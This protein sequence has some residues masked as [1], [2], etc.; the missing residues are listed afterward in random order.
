VLTRYATLLPRMVSRLRRPTRSIAVTHPYLG[1]L[2]LDFGAVAAGLLSEGF[3]TVAVRAPAAWA[4]PST[5]SPCPAILRDALRYAVAVETEEVPPDLDSDRQPIVRLW[6]TRLAQMLAQTEAAFR[7]NRPELVVLVQGYEPVNAVARAAALNLGIP[8]LAIENT[9]INSRMLWDNVSAITTNRSLAAN[10]YWRY[11]Q[12]ISEEAVSGFVESFTSGLRGSKSAEHSAPVGSTAPDCGRPNVLFLGQVFT[13]SSIVFGLGPWLS[14]LDVIEA[15]VDWCQQQGYRLLL[16]LHPKESMGNATI[17]DKPYDRLTYRRIQGR[18]A[19]MQALEENQAIVDVDNRFDTY[20]LL[21]QSDIAVTINSQAGLEAALFGK[22]AVV[23]GDAFYRGLGF[24]L[25][26]AHPVHFDLTMA[27]AITQ[28][29]RVSVRSRAGEFAY[30]YYQRY[31]RPKTVESIVDLA[32]EQLG[33][34]R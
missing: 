8:A 17:T 20:A 24:T 26:V 16:K 18:P 31:C 11:R 30:I 3:R 22:P 2:G 32:L 12:S 5:T 34:I 21:F 23:C 6:G 27:Q 33:L 4:N 19:L 13:D 28:A 15:T 7:R 10:Y 25:D 14:P 1:W 9:A 29:N